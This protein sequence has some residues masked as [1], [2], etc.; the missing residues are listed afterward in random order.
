MENPG[1]ATPVKV[2]PLGD[3]FGIT[4]P[5][6]GL[7]FNPFHREF[8]SRVGQVNFSP[9]IFAYNPSPISKSGSRKTTPNRINTPFILSPDI[10]GE[11]FPA[12]IDENPVLQLELQEKLDTQCDDEIQNKIHSFFKNHLI[13]PSPDT[14]VVNSPNKFHTSCLPRT[15]SLLP[16][17]TPLG[18]KKKNS[19]HLEDN[20]NCMC[21]VAV[22]TAISMPPSFDF[23]SIMQIAF[24]HHST[25]SPY[26]PKSFVQK[27]SR[28]STESNEILTDGNDV[29]FNP[30]HQRPNPAVN[31]ISLSACAV[32]RPTPLNSNNTLLSTL[33]KNSRHLLSRRS[34]FSDSSEINEPSYGVVDDDN[35]SNEQHTLTSSDD[36][37][38]HHHNRPNFT[39][40]QPTCST[41]LSSTQVDNSSSNVK[42]SIDKF[43]PNESSSILI[44]ETA[45][46]QM[47]L[48]ISWADHEN[49]DSSDD[50]DYHNEIINNENG[51]STD[52]DNSVSM[53]TLNRTT[54]E[55]N[56]KNSDYC[57]SVHTYIDYCSS[58]TNSPQHQQSHQQ[59]RCGS[60]SPNV[61]YTDISFQ[62]PDLSPIL[63]SHYKNSACCPSPLEGENISLVQSNTRIINENSSNCII[64]PAKCLFPPNLNASN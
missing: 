18:K 5:S 10:Q 6:G 47:C 44:K 15:S 9:G 31:N 40:T 14:V 36:L 19:Y 60:T 64:M 38:R 58:Q 29:T 39:S 25:N 4:T 20:S 56:L 1:V 45:A 34:L 62:S 52:Q 32:H 55:H 17:A 53:H 51:N 37:I 61:C 16:T 50:S 30:S 63:P 24:E 8:L 48:P 46:L 42:F 57:K 23:E 2:C 7:I 12:D 27:L 22:Q 54:V 11:L 13:A 3:E 43:S 41:Y 59:F 35:E 33:Y 49:S 26:I 28:T 21:E